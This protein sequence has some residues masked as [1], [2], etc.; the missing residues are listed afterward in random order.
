MTG[1]AKELPSNE[2]QFGTPSPEA[3]TSLL[4]QD[5]DDLR[6]LIDAATGF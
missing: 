2:A 5:P 1:A 3:G 4:L 6:T